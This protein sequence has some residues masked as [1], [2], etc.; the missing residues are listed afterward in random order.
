MARPTDKDALAALAVLRAWLLPDATP[1]LDERITL[2]PRGLVPG[3][4]DVR[5]RCVIDAARKGELRIERI[6][7]RPSVTRAELSRWAESRRFTP[8]PRA[9][10]TSEATDEYSEVVRGARQ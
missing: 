8:K 7:G 5:G 3:L 2:R 6:G 4:G 1:S 9:K 10:K